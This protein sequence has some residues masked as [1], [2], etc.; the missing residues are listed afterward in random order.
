MRRLPAV[1]VAGL[2][3]VLSACQVDTTVTVEVN[4]DGSGTI[5]VTAVA[6]ADVVE[7]APGLAEDLRFDDAVAAGWVVEGPTP[8][9]DGGL[10]VT[11]RHDFA[12]VEEATALLQSVNG[13]DG[14]LH[15]VAITRVIGD[16]EVVTTLTGTLRVDGGINAFADPELLAAI[17]G[18][19]YA[20]D[21]AATGLR[22]ADVVTFTFTAELPGDLDDAAD[23]STPPMTWTVPID[24]TAAE[25]DVIARASEGEGS[26]VW[27]L[28]ADIALIALIAWCVVAVAFIAFVIVARSRRRQ[29]RRPA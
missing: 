2:V 10:S 23:G 4:A 6:D 27:G 14:P 15:D 7:Q 1:V 9:D 12:T 26:S 21:I 16:D 20:D 13:A 8:T 3:L 28:V 22:P 19:P 18:S 5:T 11:V 17:G 24:G 25:L 29:H